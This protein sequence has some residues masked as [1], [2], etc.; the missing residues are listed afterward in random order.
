MTPV[1]RPTP[2]LWV[3]GRQSEVCARQT[4]QTRAVRCE[5]IRQRDPLRATSADRIRGVRFAV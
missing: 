5:D 2:I 1:C 3:I 4:G